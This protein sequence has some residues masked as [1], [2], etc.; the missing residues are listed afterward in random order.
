[1]R[2]EGGDDDNDCADDVPAQR[3]ILKKQSPAK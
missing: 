1:M 2:G 3:D